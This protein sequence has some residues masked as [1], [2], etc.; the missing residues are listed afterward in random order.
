MGVLLGYINSSLR[1]GNQCEMTVEQAIES[2]G[3][4]INTGSY[5]DP[6]LGE[7]SGFIDM[8]SGKLQYA[9]RRDFISPLY[10]THS[11]HIKVNGNFVLISPVAL[12]IFNELPR[13]QYDK[14]KDTLKCIYKLNK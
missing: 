1:G 11:N 10:Y 12:R 14:W 4:A 3:P 8:N 6:A 9:S 7:P 5:Y 2:L 13:N